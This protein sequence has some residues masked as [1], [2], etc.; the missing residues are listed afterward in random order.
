MVSERFVGIGA[1]I[2][3]RLPRW[4]V[5]KTE[6]QIPMYRMYFHS[7]DPAWRLLGHLESYVLAAIL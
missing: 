5:F 3:L 6:G 7:G 2:S 1:T 4:V